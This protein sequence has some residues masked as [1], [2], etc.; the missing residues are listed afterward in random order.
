MAPAASLRVGLAA[1]AGLRHRINVGLARVHRGVHVGQ[2]ALHELELADR[3]AELLALVHVRHHHV[4][5]G[6][7]D[8]KR[9]GREHRALVIQPAHQH[10]HAAPDLAEHVLLRHLA[11]LE[12]QFAGVGAAHAELV[13]LL[14]GGEP[15]EGLS[16]PGTP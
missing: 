7:H 2:L 4:H 8:A 9:S 12:H 13:E 16:P 5:A 10:V 1:V 14:G 3:L 11:I 15:F 6:L